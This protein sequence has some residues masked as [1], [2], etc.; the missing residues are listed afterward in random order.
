[1]IKRGFCAFPHGKKVMLPKILI[2]LVFFFVT[3]T[4]RAQDLIHTRN[5][6]APRDV[7]VVPPPPPP[8]TH[9]PPLTISECLMKFYEETD[10]PNWGYNWR[11]GDATHHCGEVDDDGKNIAFSWANIY[12]DGPGP[13]GVIKSVRQSANYLKGTLDGEAACIFDITTIDEMILSTNELSG[14]LPPSFG[15]QSAYSIEIADNQFN[16]FPETFYPNSHDNV[17]LRAQ[18]ND[19]TGP[20]PPTMPDMVAMADLWDNPGLECVID[21]CVSGPWVCTCPSSRRRG[22]PICNA[23]SESFCASEVELRRSLTPEEASLR[24]CL[25]DFFYATGG[26]SWGNKVNWG[27][28]GH[29]C[30]D[31]SNQI[32]SNLDCSGRRGDVRGILLHNNRLTGSLDGKASCIFD[33]PTLEQVKLGSNDLSGSLPASFGTQSSS[34]IEIFK[35]RFTRFPEV[36]V[37]NDKRVQLLAQENDFTGTIPATMTDMVHFAELWDNPNLDPASPECYSGQWSCSC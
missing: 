2:C 30:G 12:C 3:L 35:N 22:E 20:I 4:V 34:Q 11:W 23:S 19:F 1:M 32:W 14:S 6:C 33:I 8:P 37:S 17:H 7:D 10:G 13:D 28:P 18:Q 16:A 26:P 25:M 36:F 31:E 27:G 5:S 21:E 29:P 24:S 9:E 15:T